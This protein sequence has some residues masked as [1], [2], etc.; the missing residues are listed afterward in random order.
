MT[1]RTYETR[2]AGLA[3]AR[4]IAVRAGTHR[5]ISWGALFAGV[6]LALAIQL[7]LSM[8]GVGV[9]MTTIDPAQGGAPAASTLGIGAGIWWTVSYMISLAVG[10]YVAARL[11]GVVVRGDGMIHGVLTW[12]LALLVSAFLVSSALS[13][14][15]SRTFGLLGNIAGSA[16]Q[17]VQQAAPDAASALPTPDRLR[18]MAGDLLRPGDQPQGGDAQSRLTDAL[19]R[20]ASGQGGADQA[21]EEAITVI[22]EQAQVSRDVATQRVQQIE[23]QFQQ[24]RGQATQAAETTTDALSSAGIGGFIALLLGALSALFGGRAGTRDPEDVVVHG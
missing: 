6:V 9:G 4:G 23:G 12:A 11:A 1:E 14:V 7:L 5:R 17:A 22:S 21:R 3:D 16:G 2:T 20:M 8:L 10:G 19:G 18:S 15:M 24:L 13:A